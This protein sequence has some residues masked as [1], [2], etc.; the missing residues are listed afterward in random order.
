[1]SNSKRVYVVGGGTVSHVRSHL[2]LAAVAYGSTARRIAELSAEQEDAPEVLLRLTRMAD[3]NSRIETN[4]DLEA[5]VL[6]IVRDERAKIV[7][8]NSAVVDFAGSFADSPSGKYE[9]RLTTKGGAE[10]LMQLKPTPKLIGY[11]R[12]ENPTGLV[13]KDLFT[14]AFKTTCG[15][16]EQEQYLAGLH[17][18]KGASCNLVLANDTKTR[19]NMIITPE[20]A[21]YH[22]T[23]DRE[24][25]LRNLVDMAFHRSSLTFTRSTVVPG[26]PVD[27]N[28]NVVPESLRTVVNHCI[29]RGA[30]KPFRGVTAGHFAFKIDD[31]RFVTSRR[32]TN[33]NN[34]DDVGLVEIHSDGPDSV[35]AYGS[36]PSVGGQSQRIVFAEH[37]DLDCIVHFHCP[38]RPG[39]NVPSVSQREF[40]C[41]SH[42]CGRNTSNGLKSFE[43]LHAV[44][45]DNHGPNVVFHHDTDPQRVIEFIEANFDLEDKSGGYHVNE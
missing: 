20:E 25:A 10:Y 32:K 41:G 16:S 34:L 7:F 24:E 38:V 2:A 12:K 11:F 4:E 9:G 22:I 3:S 17:L 29:E 43:G 35:V 40:E 23:T 1:M 14:V 26:E 39:S 21:A 13:R 30:Y 15:A 28:S 31:N 8:F 37:P 6:E 18:L 19:V 42:E 27:W 33:F 36:R 5:L 44:Y 45:L